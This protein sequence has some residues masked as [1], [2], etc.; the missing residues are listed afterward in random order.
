MQTYAFDKTQVPTLTENA[1]YGPDPINDRLSPPQHTKLVQHIM[2][3]LHRAEPERRERMRH[4]LATEID[5]LGIVELSGTDCERKEKRENGRDVSVP[6]AIYPWGYTSLLDFTSELAAIVMPME[7]PYAV[8]V[9]TGSQTTANALVKAFR[10]QGARLDHRNNIHASIF[11]TVALDLGATEFR[12]HVERSSGTESGNLGEQIASP[13][14]VEGVQIRNLNP[15]NVAWDSAVEVAD[16]ALE[17]EFVAEYSVTKPFQLSR[18]RGSEHYLNAKFMDEIRRVVDPAD[19]DTG[20]QEPAYTAIN[21]NRLTKKSNWFYYEPYISRTRQDVLDRW[22]TNRDSAGQ[23]DMT[24]LFNTTDPSETG[25]DVSD[26]NAIHKTS[27]Y[28]RLQGSKWGLGPKLSKAAAAQEPFEIWEIR[29]YGPGYIGYAAKV[30]Y[31]L[32]R[33]PIQIST[34]NFRRKFHR[35]MKFGEH[36]AQLGLLASTVLNLYKRSLRKGLEGGLILYNPDVINLKEVSDTTGGRVPIHMNKHDDSIGRHI[37][38]LNDQPDTKNTLNHA[39]SVKAMLGSMLPSS[40][41]PAMVG[42]D[43]ATT[44]QAQAVMAT[45]QTSMLFYAALIDGQIMVPSRIF[46][47]RLNLLHPKAL[48]YIDEGKQELIT[49]AAEELAATEFEFI[50]SAPLMGVDRIRAEQ[51]LRDMV[52]VMMQ[53]GGQLPPVAAFMM[54]HYVQIAGINLDVDEYLA[55]AQKEVDEAQQQEAA[56][57]EGAQPAAQQ[58]APRVGPA[59]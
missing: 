55:A 53:S 50:Q 21:G 8:A 19:D 20:Y 31:K 25:V 44:Y 42:L 30:T 34:M 27:I 35:S 14:D 29:L 1:Q 58:G 54:K 3:A 9:G 28:I 10:A 36:A 49:L 15:Y 47:H 6:D 45:S 23:T 33:F 37:L 18:R 43:R 13:A 11:D 22:G 48:K 4:M 57:A 38:Q 56:A 5:L 2:K 17:G 32:D 51:I 46:M 40:A 59:T 16:L 26:P 7:A 52:N 41:Q 24:N 39:E 12:W